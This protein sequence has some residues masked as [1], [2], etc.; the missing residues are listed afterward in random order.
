MCG[1]HFDYLW[2]NLVSLA[3]C[4]TDT[5]AVNYGLAVSDV[6][7]DF[8][9]LLFPIPFVGSYVV[10]FVEDVLTSNRFGSYKC[11][12]VANLPSLVYSSSVPCML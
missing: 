2:T 5:V 3:K 8:L 7:M 1:N 4:P 10:I 11:L 6:I 9:I 12:L